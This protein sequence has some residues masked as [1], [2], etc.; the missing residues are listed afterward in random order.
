MGAAGNYIRTPVT[1]FLG[2]RTWH[3]KDVDVP[4]YAFQTSLSN[5]AV[6]KGARAF[7]RASKVPR[8]KYVDRAS[9]YAHLDPLTA[10]PARNDFLKTVV[11][12]L[13][14]LR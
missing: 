9:T 7:V 12:F 3:R 8:A 5:G 1:D 14:T 4:L 11:P 10:T 2:L 13:R 6:L